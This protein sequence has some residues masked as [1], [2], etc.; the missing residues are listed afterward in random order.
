MFLILIYF[1]FYPFALYITTC[2]CNCNAQ[3]PPTMK[4]AVAGDQSY[5]STILRFFVEQL[6]NKTPDWLS[7]IRFLVIPIG[8]S[9]KISVNRPPHTHFLPPCSMCFTGIVRNILLCVPAQVLIPWQSTWPPLTAGSTASLWTLRGGSCSAG[10][11]GLPRVG[12][13]VSGACVA[14]VQS[15]W[16]RNGEVKSRV[17]SWWDERKW[18]HSPANNGYS[19]VLMEFIIL[20]LRESDATLFLYC[21]LFC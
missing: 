7:Y 16:K 15:S 13:R 2:S 20:F 18:L 1:F 3:T 9:T 8:K 4:V 5:L 11:S 14:Q 17:I 10:R 6:A 21:I 12:T 19:L